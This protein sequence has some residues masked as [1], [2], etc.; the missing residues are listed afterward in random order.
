MRK[1][2]NWRRAATTHCVNGHEYTPENTYTRSEGWRACRAC[3]RE[4]VR[5]Y[6]D[7]RA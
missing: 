3:N 7:N 6:Q 5:R 1:G 4:A 2:R